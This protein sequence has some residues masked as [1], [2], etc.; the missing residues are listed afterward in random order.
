MGPAGRV[1]HPGRLESP[2]HPLSGSQP[3]RLPLGLPHAMLHVTVGLCPYCFCQLLGL[4]S[5]PFSIRKSSYSLSRPQSKHKVLGQNFPDAPGLVKGP[6]VGLCRPMPFSLIALCIVFM[7][8]N[9]LKKKN[10]NLSSSL[11]CKLHKDKYHVC[12]YLPGCPRGLALNS[13]TS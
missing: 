2:C 1:A 7:Y 10:E 13:V 6:I 5:V 3:H 11:N 9:G 12:F 8:L 4:P